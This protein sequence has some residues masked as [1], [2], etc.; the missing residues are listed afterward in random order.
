MNI[1]KR[2]LL[3]AFSIAIFICGQIKCDNPND[4]ANLALL[5]AISH[6]RTYSDCQISNEKAKS[7]CNCNSHVLRV[8]SPSIFIIII[9]KK[10]LII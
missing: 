9:K 7:I 4:M 6:L 1:F 3:N 8:M 5:F 10:Q 2:K